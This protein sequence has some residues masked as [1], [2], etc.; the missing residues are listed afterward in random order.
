MALDVLWM[1]VRGVR[2]VVFVYGSN[3]Q[4]DT[5]NRCI[6][7]KGGTLIRVARLAH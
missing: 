5:N 6:G 1:M 7:K 4:L 2:V 3:E